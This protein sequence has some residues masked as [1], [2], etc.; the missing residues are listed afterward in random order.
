MQ[1]RNRQALIQRVGLT[2][3]RELPAPVRVALPASRTR[4]RR[5]H[6]DQA[7]S[8]ACCHD[9]RVRRSQPRDRPCVSAGGRSAAKAAIFI[10]AARSDRPRRGFFGRRRRCRNISSA[11]R[12]RSAVLLPTSGGLTLHLSAPPMAGPAGVEIERLFTR[13]CVYKPSASTARTAPHVSS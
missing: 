1:D 5:A 13:H 10:S 11:T 8:G 12:R 7:D 9:R 6:F 4:T 2:K 3:P